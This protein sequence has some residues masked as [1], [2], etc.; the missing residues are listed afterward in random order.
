MKILVEFLNGNRED[1]NGK[2]SNWQCGIALWNNQNYGIATESKRKWSAKY[3]YM[4]G[5]LIIPDYTKLNEN[6]KKS[7]YKY[8]VE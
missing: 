7:N 8:Y 2:K 1:A 3:K 4:D 6:Y 5:N